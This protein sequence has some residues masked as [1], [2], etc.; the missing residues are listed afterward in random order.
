MIDHFSQPVVG[1]FDPSIL[2]SADFCSHSMDF[3][4]VTLEEMQTIEIPFT[5]VINKTSILHGIASWFD[6]DFNGSTAV[7]KLSTSPSS[8]AT[9]WYQCRLLL[10]TPIAVNATQSISGKIVMVANKHKSYTISLVVNLD[11]T[12]ISSST[13]I[14]LQDQM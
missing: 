4:S 3:H 13:V 12:S 6:V 8:A 11:G 7:I 2:I 5:F 14:S 10:M 1:Y 9:H